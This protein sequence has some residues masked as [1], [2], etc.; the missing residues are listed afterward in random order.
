MKEKT[1]F[2]IKFLLFTESLFLLVTVIA[3]I[4]CIIFSVH[5]D[6]VLYLY[7]L[8]VGVIAFILTLLIEPIVD[9]IFKL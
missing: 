6:F 9:K 4:F 5:F 7:M 1:I 8:T 3:N 2:N